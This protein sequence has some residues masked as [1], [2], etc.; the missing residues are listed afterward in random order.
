MAKCTWW[1]LCLLAAISLAVLGCDVRIVDVGTSS[2]RGIRGSGHIVTTDYQLTGFSAIAVDSGFTVDASQSD[3]FSVAVTSDDNVVPYLQVTQQ[4][5]TLKIA[6]Q[7]G[8]YTNTTLRATVSMP[9]LT[10]I[11]LNGGSRMT[12]AGFNEVE[13]LDLSTNGGATLTLK[14]AGNSLTANGNGGSRFDLSAF[15]VT[16]ATVE[17]NGGSTG[18]VNVNGGP[19]NVTASGGA[20]LEYTG[21]PS[22][23]TRAIS[24]G[25]S[26]VG[27]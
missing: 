21:K 8:S 10:G 5:Q 13:A 11:D 1:M 3:V 22:G 20:R 26:V 18:I 19:L 7:S 16:T 23:G 12:A 27:R 24:G 4:G 6:L 9:Q 2:P 25:A 15:P 17:V 14:G